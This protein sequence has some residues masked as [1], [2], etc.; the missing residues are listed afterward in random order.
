MID[1]QK[2]GR[3][4]TYAFKGLKY[5]LSENNA[6]IHLWAAIWAIGL[7][8][9]LSIKPTEWLFVALAIVLVLMAE[10]FN[11]AI[12]RL[13]DLASPQRHPL[14]GQAKDLSAAA[15][16]LAAMFALVVAGLVFLPYFV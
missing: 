4:L 14:A 6:R 5:L 7:G 11:T 2:F 15:V 3:S 13:T 16:L 9:Y 8:I 1:F 12:E 10:A